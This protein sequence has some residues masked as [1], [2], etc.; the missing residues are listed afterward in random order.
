VSEVKNDK[1][2]L[3]SDS[4]LISASFVPWDTEALGFSV[5]QIK[6]F[7]IRKKQGVTDGFSRFKAW[8]RANS[9]G[10]VSCRLPLQFLSESMFLESHGFRFI[11]TV[12]HPEFSGLQG[13]RLPDMGLSVEPAAE[14]DLP[15]LGK[16]AED[17]FEKERFHIDPRIDSVCGDRRYSNWVFSSFKDPEQQL[18]K[19]VNKGTVIALF[20][21]EELENNAVCW[22][23]TAVAKP[24]QGRGYGGRAAMAM[25][26]Y[27]RSL[28]KKLVWTT[29]STR[30]TRVLNLCA[31]LGFRFISPEMTFHWLVDSV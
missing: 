9:Y 27:H 1:F 23:L 18:L 20:I 28:G 10:L 6:E 15:E 22:H 30:N 8:C 12:I 19:V 2:Y 11:E 31:G 29:I 17:V 7:R 13:L 24:F 4:L 5:A 3:D 25:L 14:P 16:I 26:R 21:I